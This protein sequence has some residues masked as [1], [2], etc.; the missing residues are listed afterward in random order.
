MVD[1]A[2]ALARWQMD[3]AAV[4]QRMYRSPTPRERERWHAVWLLAQGWSAAKVAELL[5][6]DPHT[7][8]DWLSA[9]AEGGPPAL[10]FE[11]TGGAPPPSTQRS[12]SR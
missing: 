8:S 2:D 9:F 3:E 1:I 6:R 11:Q 5:E 12:R 7:I 4:R 10:G